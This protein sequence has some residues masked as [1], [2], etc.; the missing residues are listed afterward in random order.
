MELNMLTFVSILAIIATV[1][2]VA[3]YVR[4]AVS[5]IKQHRGNSAVI[6]TGDD[7]TSFGWQVALAVFA[8]SAIIGLMGVYPPLIYAGPLL[9]LATAAMNGFAFFYDKA[10]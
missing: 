9:V 4:G 8:A 10:D 3:G 5:A 1:L 6:D 2:F 7:S